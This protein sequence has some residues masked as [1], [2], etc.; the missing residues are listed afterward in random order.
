[1]AQNFPITACPKC[2]YALQ[3]HYCQ[4]S[5][6]DTDNVI[7]TFLAS[8]IKNGSVLSVISFESYI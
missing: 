3:M 5:T 6:A 7:N 8:R 2:Y 4:G 1:M